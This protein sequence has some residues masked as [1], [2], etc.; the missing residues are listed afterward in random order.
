MANTEMRSAMESLAC[1]AIKCAAGEFDPI[2]E[3]SEMIRFKANHFLIVDEHLH[4]F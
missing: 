1:T 3:F 4:V 2:E